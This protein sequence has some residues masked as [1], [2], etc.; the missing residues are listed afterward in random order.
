M[1]AV[2]YM[3]KL[4]TIRKGA[5]VIFNPY[6]HATDA[7]DGTWYRMRQGQEARVVEMGGPHD[8]IRF[9][10]KF[11]SDGYV[12]DKAYPANWLICLNW[13]QKLRRLFRRERQ[14]IIIPSYAHP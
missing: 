7:T 13:K 5:V 14:G 6:P 12:T 10:L 2:V 1:S 8:G 4:V 3:K 9:R 11:L